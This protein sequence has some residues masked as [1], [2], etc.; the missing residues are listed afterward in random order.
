MNPISTEK[1][2]HF[3]GD[4]L[5]HGINYINHL[6]GIVSN[7]VHKMVFLDDLNPSYHLDFYRSIKFAIV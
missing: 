4:Y 2:K 5:G 1:L 6:N 3:R 7:S